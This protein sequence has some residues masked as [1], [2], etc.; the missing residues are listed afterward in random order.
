MYWKKKTTL[1]ILVLAFAGG[2]AQADFVFG[3][4][5]NLGPTVNTSAHDTIPSISVDG[6]ELYFESNRA[7]GSGNWD[8]WVATRANTNVEWGAPVN[9]GSHINSSSWDGGPCLSPDGLELYF[10]SMRPGGYGA[11]DTWVTRR[12]TK[13]DAWG[14]PVNLGSSFNTSA[15][16][17]F[18][19]FSSDGLTLYFSDYS[20]FQPG[21]FGKSDLWMTVRPTVSDPWETPL[22]LGPTV[23]SANHDQI[24]SISSDGLML[25]FAS[26]RPGGQGKTDI[27]MARR[28]TEADDWSTPVNLGSVINSSHWDDGVSISADGRTL[29]FHSMNR[30]GGYGGQDLWQASINPVVDF[31]GDGHVDCIDI[32][33]L[34]D[35]WGT[36]NMLYDI[37]PM[38]WGDGTVDEIDLLVLAEYMVENN[39]ANEL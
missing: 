33:D 17:G 12:T 32:Y 38:P 34:I 16:E 15:D 23:N 28:A 19:T 39:D 26:N 7:G 2:S 22:N 24:P 30:S 6:L 25:F 31:N 5:L 27:W 9:L 3:E 21:G 4:P 36:D 14:T 37:G 8:V 20:T 11:V 1:L 35:Q 18:V 13:D 10:S 29:Y